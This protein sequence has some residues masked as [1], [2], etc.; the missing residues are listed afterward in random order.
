MSAY[1]M[2]CSGVVL[3]AI[4]VM[5]LALYYTVWVR[6]YRRFATRDPSIPPV[7]GEGRVMRLSRKLPI[8]HTDP[9]ACFIPEP[10]VTTLYDIVWSSVKKYATRDCMGT[11]DILGIQTK[12]EMI[13]GVEKPVNYYKLGPYTWVT[14]AEVGKT[15]NQLAAFL[16]QDLKTKQGDVIGFFCETCPAWLQLS[17]ACHTLSATPVTIYTTI[18]FEGTC[19]AIQEANLPI[20]LC[21]NE[22]IV[23]L[24][25]VA[26]CCPMLTHVICKDSDPPADVVQ[27]LQQCGVSVHTIPAILSVDRPPPIHCAPSP[28]TLAFIIYTSGSTGTPKGVLV[29]HRSMLTGITGGMHSTG[30]NGDDTFIAY[31]PMA[32]VIENNTEYAFFWL[33][34]KW[35]Y[36]SARTLTGQ[37]CYECSG[38]IP[39]L[40]PTIMIGVPAVWERLRKVIISRVSKQPRATRVVF[41]LSLWIRKRFSGRL[42][43]T[44][45]GKVINYVLDKAVFHKF[46]AIAGGR[47]RVILSGGAP[48][49]AVTQKFLRSTLCPVFIQAYGI[50]ETAAV[51][52][53]QLP[54]NTSVCRCGPPSCCCE[55]KLIDVPELGYS[56]S[57]WPRARGEILVRGKNI[58]AGYFK[59]DELTKQSFDSDGWFH[60][61]DIG[62]WHW[63]GSL[64]LIDRRKNI[65][66]LHNGEYVALEKVESAYCLSRFVDMVCAHVD[67]N[68]SLPIALVI[69]N[70]EAISEI[71]P[72][73]MENPKEYQA[74]CKDPKVRQAVLESIQ[75][76]SQKARL[77]K[78]EIPNAILMITDKWAPETGLTTPSMKLKR[79][80]IYD[81][82]DSQIREL[83]RSLA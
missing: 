13:D 79:T 45:I 34:A 24:P 65:A 63:D 62:T 82:Y 74:A 50:T 21:S 54:A 66:K 60:T 11:R 36:S 19:H 8:R 48:L 81:K 77:V 41:K 2:F 15:I 51:V 55:V 42:R 4:Y 27:A 49:A 76:S 46:H 75:S 38:D 57:D 16:Q 59:Q 28:S 17:S 5:Y 12:I 18:G 10:T 32:H 31:L 30:I 80:A 29:T 35:G 64:E 72:G 73:N 43:H 47:L 39:A 20:L 53:F 67:S 78:Y 40:R 7:K 22:T 56:S 33:G 14:Y 9:V 71:H 70:K 25:K 58:A 26:S 23:H 83:Y 68:Q 61:G 44:F 52:S 3:F 69:P 1:V 6:W 37:F